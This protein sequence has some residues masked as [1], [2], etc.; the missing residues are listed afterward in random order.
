MELSKAA[1]SKTNIQKESDV[2]RICKDALEKISKTLFEDYD[3][4][5][6]GFSHAPKFPRPSEI[7]VLMKQYL[8]KKVI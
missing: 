3:G 2:N 1:L 5:F 4:K 8:V 6:G 7:N